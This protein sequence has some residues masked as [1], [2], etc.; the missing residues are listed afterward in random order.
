MKS[1]I[2]VFFWVT[3][4]LGLVL[5][6]IVLLLQ[7]VPPATIGVL[8][9]NLGGGI[10]EI[11]Y[12]MGY[13]LGVS[14][15]HKWFLLDGTV[16]FLTYARANAEITGRMRDNL[17]GRKLALDIRTKDNNTAYFDV[18]VTYRILEG[19][20][21]KIVME[22]NQYKYQS[23]A[24]TAVQA[25]LRAELAQ[26]SSEDVYATDKRL[27]VVNRAMPKLR[28]SMARWHLEPITLLIRAVNFPPNYEEKLLQ[29][30]LTQQEKLLATAKRKVE[31]EQAETEGYAAE[32]EA[33]EKESRGDWDKKLQQE[34]S[35]NQVLI[36]R[37]NAEADKYSRETRAK[38]DAD[39]ETMVA[40]G[41]LELAKAEALRDELRNAALDT[42]G[43]RI[44]L[45]RQAAEN[46]QFES[47]TLNSNDP[48]VPSV[49]DIGA[50][51]RLLVG[52]KE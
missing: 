37:I 30:Q 46:L 2:R 19:A 25:V 8:Q 5:L 26:L 42:A 41:D 31:D 16:H 11:D 48:S 13:H 50:L 7:K 23:Q 44:F 43:G 51:V 34:Q 9:N 52:P 12:Q 21:H 3:G 32:T 6:G 28:E 17:E 20:G 4:S 40:A 47:V 49:L 14:G 39:F 22:G 1:A 18:T 10:E 27:D 35:E 33:M 36:A 15:V 38:T 29:K 24:D 45:A